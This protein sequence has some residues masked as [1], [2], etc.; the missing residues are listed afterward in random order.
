MGR[1]G[2]MFAYQLSNIEPD[3]MTLGKG[4]G[5]GVPLSALLCREEV[6]CFEP[7]DQGG[8]YNGNPVMTAVGLAVMQTLLEPGFMQSVRDKGVSLRAALLKL[9]RKRVV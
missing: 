8:T 7:G 9:D 6:A 2:E 3:I 1:C 4:I 5:G